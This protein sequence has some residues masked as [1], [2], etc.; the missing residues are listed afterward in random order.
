MISRFTKRAIFPS[1]SGIAPLL[2]RPPKVYLPFISFGPLFSDASSSGECVV[3]NYRI[4]GDFELPFRVFPF[5]EEIDEG[6]VD[7]ILKL[8]ADIPEA[9]AGASVSVTLPV[10]RHTLSCKCTLPDSAQGQT[11]EYVDQEKVVVWQ[12]KKFPG[13]SEQQIR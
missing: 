13:Q 2:C 5:I 8:R 12:I 1:L 3:L 9:N 6:R 4:S 10:P 11:A 7:V